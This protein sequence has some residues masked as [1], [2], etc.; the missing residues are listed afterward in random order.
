[1]VLVVLLRES[2]TYSTDNIMIYYT[3][4]YEP[5]T[6]KLIVLLL[7]C[8]IIILLLLCSDIHGA[9]VIMVVVLHY[10]H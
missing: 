9:T 4:M 2:L 3:C 7:I 6:I 5:G 1:M 8:S 10:K